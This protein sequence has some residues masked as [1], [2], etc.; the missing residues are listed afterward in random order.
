VCSLSFLANL[1]LSDQSCSDHIM[2]SP[3]LPINSLRMY[4]L[5]LFTSKTPPHNYS[6]SVTCAIL[7]TD[8]SLSANENGASTV[9]GI[10]HRMFASQCQSFGLILPFGHDLPR[11]RSSV[12]SSTTS[13]KRRPFFRAHSPPSG[14]L[15]R[16]HRDNSGSLSWP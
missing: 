4:H 12:Q 16:Y 2:K 7:L 3:I 10:L 13:Q 15:W 11:E 1:I 14:S 6:G 8:R 5:Q 9:S